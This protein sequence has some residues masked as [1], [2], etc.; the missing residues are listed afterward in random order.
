[1]DISIPILQLKELSFMELKQ[2]AYDYIVS[3]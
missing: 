3:E 1:M 2:Y